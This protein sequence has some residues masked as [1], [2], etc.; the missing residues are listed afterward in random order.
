MKLQVQNFVQSQRIDLIGLVQWFSARDDSGFLGDISCVQRHVRL[1]QPGRVCP[2]VVLWVEAGDAA[3]HLMIHRIAGVTKSDLPPKLKV[4]R[5]RD[6]TVP[7]CR[8]AM[9]MQTQ[10]TDLWTV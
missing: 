5:L 10:R 3:A 4:P 2:P 1:S 9:D 8:A 6:P 7:V